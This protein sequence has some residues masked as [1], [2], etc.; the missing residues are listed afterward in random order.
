MLL[1]VLVILVILGNAFQGIARFSVKQL[2]TT[3]P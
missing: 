1:L 3:K 2:T